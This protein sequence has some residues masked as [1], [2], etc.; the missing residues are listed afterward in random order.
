[1]GAIDDRRGDRR[2]HRVSNLVWGLD[3]RP[4]GGRSYGGGIVSLLTQFGGLGLAVWLVYYHT[5]VTYPNMQ[6]EHREERQA[7]LMQ[8]KAEIDLKRTEYLESLE[9]LTVQYT[10]ELHERRLE[11]IKAIEA[12][13]CKAK[14]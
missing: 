5:T 9:K 6:R 7:A 13:G 3:A 1:M 8:F 11:I 14:I 4:N 10:T 2:N 12:N